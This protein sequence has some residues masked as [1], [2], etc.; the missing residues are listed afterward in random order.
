MHTTIVKIGYKESNGL[1]K[2]IYVVG[3]ESAVQIINEYM[4]RYDSI[5]V[6][7]TEHIALD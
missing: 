5:S 7:T 6:R 2:Y 1:W 4:D 3:K